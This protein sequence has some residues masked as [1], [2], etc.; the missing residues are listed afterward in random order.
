[1][2]KLKSYSINY[3]KLIR[4]III[5]C[6]LENVSK[7]YEIIKLKKKNNDSLNVSQCTI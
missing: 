2:I 3:I 6:E 4:S 5:N 1:M 7:T